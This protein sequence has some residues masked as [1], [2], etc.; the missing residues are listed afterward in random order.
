MFS[1]IALQPEYKVQT[2]REG[3][4]ELFV[5]DHNKLPPPHLPVVTL[6]S[7]NLCLSITLGVATCIHLSLK[8]GRR[9]PAP[10][11]IPIYSNLL[12]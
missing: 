9:P 6:L 5:A 8:P 1:P 7:L 12:T 2:P 4:G 11:P 10:S 3:A